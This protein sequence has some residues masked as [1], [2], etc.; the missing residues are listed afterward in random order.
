MIMQTICAVGLDCD[1]L[2]L[3][4][5]C[6]RHNRF[7]PLCESEIQS[8]SFDLLEALRA[9]ADSLENQI[10][11]QEKNHGFSVEKVCCLLPFS[12]ART[13]IV[14]DV[15]PLTSGRKRRLTARDVSL[16]K[17]HIENVALDWQDM[18]IHNIVL[19][20]FLDDRRHLFLPPVSEARKLKLK[21]QLVFI[22]RKLYKEVENIFDNI[23]RKFMG[24]VFSPLCDI[25]V[26]HTGYSRSVP[27]LTC[28]I[29]R[30]NTLGAGLRGNELFFESFDL[31]EIKL[32]Q[33]LAGRFLF[34]PEVCAEIF[35][36]YISLAPTS[37]HKEVVVKD[38]NQYVNVSVGSLSS[39]IQDRLAEELAKIIPRIE[40]LA[41]GQ[42]KVLFL[43]K[44]TL[45]QGFMSFIRDRFPSL[46][47]EPLGFRSPSAPF[48]GCCHYAGRYFLER[49]FL[50]GKNIWKKLLEFYRE[51]F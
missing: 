26:N 40:S 13:K 20:Y 30:M 2:R 48:L 8:L 23:G 12:Y 35:D 27:Y 25:S 17:E 46:S 21:S 28:N 31:G 43:G 11:K 7:V 41:G 47:V 1:K 18:R 38:G 5:S 34:S 49:E 50:P 4:F 37:V 16:A 42:Q 44:V 51:Y 32:E 29:G 10:R 3:L 15:L 14:E 19:E 45:L 33:A 6:H 9:K 36:R 24:F 22:E 39:F